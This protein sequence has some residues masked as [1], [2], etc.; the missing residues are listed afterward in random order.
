MRSLPIILLLTFLHG[1]LATYGPNNTRT[2]LALELFDVMG[3]EKQFTMMINSAREMQWK[4]IT[5]KASPEEREK[6]AA[7][8]KRIE[9]VF[10]KHFNFSIIVK[11]MAAVYA[12]ELT[13][14][15]LN[16]LLNFYRSDI[17]ITFLTKLPA[18]M[19]KSMLITQELLQEISPHVEE[20]LDEWKEKAQQLD[21]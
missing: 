9:E 8:R 11:R 7:L 16:G 14:T 15:E 4:A 1:A 10:D 20:A 19:Q 2:K 18:L 5:E 21:E 6:Q 17:G 3:T 13:E 12:S